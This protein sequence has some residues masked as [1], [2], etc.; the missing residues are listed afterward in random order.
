MSLVALSVPPQATPS[1]LI[2]ESPIERHWLAITNHGTA[3]VF[4]ALDG[5]AR[6]TS[7]LLTPSGGVAPGILL[8]AGATHFFSRNEASPNSNTSPVYVVQQSGSAQQVT[9][10]YLP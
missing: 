9:A 7:A 2:P 4:Y 3:P 10:Q 1:L 6:D 5:V 8:P